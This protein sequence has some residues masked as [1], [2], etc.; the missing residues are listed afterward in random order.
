M[1]AAQRKSRAVQVRRLHFFPPAMCDEPSIK[2]DRVVPACCTAA[3]SSC[4]DAFKCVGSTL[5]FAPMTLPELRAAAGTAPCLPSAMCCTVPLCQRLRVVVIRA[6]PWDAAPGTPIDPTCTYQPANQPRPKC[7]PALTSGL[8]FKVNLAGTPCAV[9]IPY[10][11][12][13]V[14]L[15]EY[16]TISPSAMSTF[17]FDFGLGC[18]RK[19]SG[20]M[21]AMGLDGAAS[22]SLAFTYTWCGA[23]CKGVTIPTSF[24]VTDCTY[25]NVRFDVVNNTSFLSN[26]P[27]APSY[28]VLQIRQYCCEDETNPCVP[29]PCCWGTVT[30]PVCPDPPATCRPGSLNCLDKTGMQK[31]LAWSGL[32]KTPRH[33]RSRQRR[34]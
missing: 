7:Q 24:T 14:I 21:L 15:G 31:T 19:A 26:D 13:A 20:K 12:P 6:C 10:D 22:A 29:G 16:S 28:V 25:T 5:A 33:V 3:S 1:I 2:G 4:F 34:D 30:D 32:G 8:S 9:P 11:P 18:A 27:C 23:R 17:E